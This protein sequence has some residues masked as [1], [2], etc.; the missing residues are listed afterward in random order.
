MRDLAYTG[1]DYLV[2]V[3]EDN[4]MKIW[5]TSEKNKAILTVR[6]HMGPIFT[7]VSHGGMLFTG[8]MEG[9]IRAWNIELDKGLPT[10]KAQGEW[11]NS[12]EGRYDPIWQLAFSSNEV[13]VP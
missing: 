9:I 5:T 4:T 3:S 1:E 10:C 8:G 11:N 6:E 2:S 7:C 13:L 12:T